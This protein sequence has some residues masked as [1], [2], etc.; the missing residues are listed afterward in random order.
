[1]FI[2]DHLRVQSLLLL[3]IAR[4]S[5]KKKK[6]LRKVSCT[7]LSSSRTIQTR[8][9]KKNFSKKKSEKSDATPATP[10]VP[11]AVKP[12]DAGGANENARSNSSE[13]KN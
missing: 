12:S 6:K 9:S 1:L 11:T 7:N 8:S 10:R 2:R 5:N 4:S 13:T 3:L